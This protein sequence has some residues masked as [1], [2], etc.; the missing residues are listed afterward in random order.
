MKKIDYVVRPYIHKSGRVMVR[1]RWNSSKTET[2]FTTGSSADPQ[3]WNKDANR[4]KINTTH[5]VKGV[6]YP[7]KDINARIESLL[8]V[9]S[10]VFYKFEVAEKMPTVDQLKQEVNLILRPVLSSSILSDLGIENAKG[11]YLQD[12][13]DDFIVSRPMELNWGTKTHLRYKEVVD[14]YYAYSKK[15][16][17]RLLEINKRTLTEFK[18]WFFDNKN[19]KKPYSNYTVMKHFRNFKGILNWGKENGY[20][21]HPESISFKAN[22]Q[23]IRKT[24]TFLNYDEIVRLATYEF[25]AS[26]KYLDHVRDVFCFGCYTSLRHSDLYSLRKANVK[27]DIIEIVTQKTDDLLHIPLI[28]QAKAI[29]EKYK[30]LPGDR[31]LPVVSDQKSNTYIKEAAKLAGLSRD[32]VEVNM[33]GNERVDNVY[34][35]YETISMHDARRSFVCNS[36]AFGIPANVVKACTG[37]ADLNTMKPYIATSDTTVKKELKKWSSKPVRLRIDSLLDEATDEQLEA[38]YVLLNDTLKIVI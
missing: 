38:V 13:L 29:L 18:A 2:V 10:Q 4:A 35:L 22:I 20:K 3:K 31:A 26:K 12:L 6:T 36:L 14:K 28:P 7:S 15:K 21:V 32:V 11:I 33:V 9:I 19:H 1:V 5:N 16:N 8:D 27:G 34:K 17:V 37:H 30:D 24:V 25:P 23:T